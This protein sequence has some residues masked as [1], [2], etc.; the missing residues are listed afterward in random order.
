MPI[1]ITIRIEDN[2]PRL[3][4]PR[5]EFS[6]ATLGTS[7]AAIA[8]LNIGEDKGDPFTAAGPKARQGCAEAT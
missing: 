5:C 1:G 4:T 3:R 7:R 6:R 2:S 8:V